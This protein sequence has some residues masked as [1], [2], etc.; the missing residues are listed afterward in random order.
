MKP[1]DWMVTYTP[2]TDW[3]KGGGAIVWLSFFAGLFGSGAY[4]ASLYFDS[5]T[6]T[7][8]SWLIIA[9]LK[10][11]LHVGHA[12]KPLRLWRMVLKVRTSWIS[13]GHGLYGLCR[14][15]RRCPDNPLL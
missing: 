2:Q 15:L 11:G 1:Y 5:F 10:G 7:V 14:P 12:K 4:L 13:E 9:V 6:G 8:V 3:I